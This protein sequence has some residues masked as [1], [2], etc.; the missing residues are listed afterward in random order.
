MEK[1]SIIQIYKEFQF[2]YSE[3][4]VIYRITAQLYCM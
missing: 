1:E 3:Y 2:I 4:H